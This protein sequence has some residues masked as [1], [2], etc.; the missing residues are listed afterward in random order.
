[1]R[2]SG[3]STGTSSRAAGYEAIVANKLGVLAD[4]PVVAVT[5]QAVRAWHAGLDKDKPTARE[6]A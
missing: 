2:G 3:S 4:V 5:A 1:M 6:P